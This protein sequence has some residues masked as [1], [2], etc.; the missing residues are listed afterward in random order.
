MA[1]VTRSSI[2]LSA[3]L[4]LFGVNRSIAKYVEFDQSVYQFTKNYCIKCHGSE[5][6]KGDR[7]FHELSKEVSGKRMIDL[8]DDEKVN[9]MHDLLEQLNLGEMPPKK[10][11]VK[12][13]KTVEI[14]QAID[15]NKLNKSN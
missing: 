9:L 15:F 2:F 3:V 12:Q 13:P 1:W 8:G 5:K 14:K 11:D 7:T 4:L 6:E 10:D